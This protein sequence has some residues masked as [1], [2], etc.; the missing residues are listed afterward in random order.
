[1]LLSSIVGVRRFS[2]F[3]WVCGP[4]LQSPRPPWCKVVTL[5]SRLVSFFVLPKV[6]FHVGVV[7]DP[8]KSLPKSILLTAM[9]MNR[10]CL[11][12][13]VQRFFVSRPF[14]ATRT[15]WVIGLPPDFLWQDG[16]S[17]FS[18]FPFPLVSHSFPW[19]DPRGA[20]SLQVPPCIRGS[21]GRSL[22]VSPQACELSLSTLCFSLPSL[23]VQG[24]FPPAD[25]C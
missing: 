2:V 14:F 25:L 15:R 7:S 9:R 11:L 12:P 17:C 24:V 18:S 23:F 4:G 13:A 3:L 16:I 20:G 22:L 21:F 19:M 1:V 5:P 10:L 6:F 8:L